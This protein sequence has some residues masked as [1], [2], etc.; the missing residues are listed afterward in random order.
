MP[1]VDINASDSV[2]KETALTAASSNGHKDTT[3]FLLRRGASVVNINGHLAPPL[4]CAVREGQEEIACLLLQHQAD[5]DQVD[6][7]GRTALMMSVSEG[8]TSLTDLLLLRGRF[9]TA[10]Q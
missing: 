9:C 2:S 8:H 7:F 1:E 3:V 10:T 4:L 6:G 5:I